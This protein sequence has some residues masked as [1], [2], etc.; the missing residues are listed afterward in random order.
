MNEIKIRNETEED[1]WSTFILWKNAR[2][3]GERHI[4]RP[5]EMNSDNYNIV[6]NDRHLFSDDTVL[7]T[8]NISEIYEKLKNMKMLQPSI[9]LNQLE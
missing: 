4:K 7:K 8:N 2:N 9:K 1:K 6:K 5:N 3:K